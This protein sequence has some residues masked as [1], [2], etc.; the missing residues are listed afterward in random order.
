MD[1]CGWFLF[2]VVFWI[3]VPGSVVVVCCYYFWLENDDLS[4][5][6]TTKS[7][8]VESDK[9]PIVC[10]ENQADRL[11]IA[12]KY[13]YTEAGG[14]RLHLLSLTVSGS[15]KLSTLILQTLF[16]FPLS[17]QWDNRQHL[18]VSW[19]WLA[20]EKQHILSN[21]VWLHA[22]SLATHCVQYF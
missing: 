3:H 18:H 16:L 15:K 13:W 1:L 9:V 21:S 7:S 14:S 5:L 19:W 4:T 2:L 10:V 12:C 22:P 17:G 6:R 11:T 8:K 20:A